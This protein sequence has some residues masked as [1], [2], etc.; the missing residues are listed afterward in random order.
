VLNLKFKTS[1]QVGFH[2]L[3]SFFPFSW[4]TAW[5]PVRC[6]R[7]SSAVQCWLV[8]WFKYEQSVLV[9]DCFSGVFS[10]S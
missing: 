8:R 2:F 1:E 9:D 6:L 10:E 3:S 5:I 7:F 4:C